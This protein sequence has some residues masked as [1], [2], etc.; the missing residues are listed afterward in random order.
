[1]ILYTIE[2]T[3]SILFW[4]QQKLSK[5]KLM[6]MRFHP[7]LP[8]SF[9]K[10]FSWMT[11]LSSL[12]SI[13]RAT[14]E[15]GHIIVCVIWN[16]SDYKFCRGNVYKAGTSIYFHPAPYKA[17]LAILTLEFYI[18]L[19]DNPYF[20]FL[21]FVYSNSQRQMAAVIFSWAHVPVI[22]FWPQSSAKRR[23]IE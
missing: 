22:D 20:V 8:P 15:I 12:Y 2:K 5:T 1:M 18:R 7:L 4:R 9:F 23:V 14:S 13:F 10:P 16:W 21:A 19:F 6:R 3:N 17:I 11:Y